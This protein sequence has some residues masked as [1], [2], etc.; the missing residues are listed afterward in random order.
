MHSDVL[1][2]YIRINIV[3]RILT[4]VTENRVA[5]AKVSEASGHSN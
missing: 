5:P 4:N 3:P 1:N 2:L